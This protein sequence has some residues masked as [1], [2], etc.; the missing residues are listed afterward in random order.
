MKSLFLEFAK[1]ISPPKIPLIVQWELCFVFFSLLHDTF[2]Y[3]CNL[4]SGG[5]YSLKNTVLIQ[6]EGHHKIQ[7]RFFDVY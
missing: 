4:I 2:L 3:W 1:H 5:T 7:L 6:K